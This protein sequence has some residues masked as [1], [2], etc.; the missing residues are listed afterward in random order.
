M[1]DPGRFD[2]EEEALRSVSPIEGALGRNASDYNNM[3]SLFCQIVERASAMNADPDA[4]LTPTGRYDDKSLNAWTKMIA[5]A[6]SILEGLNKMRNSDRLTAHIL[7]KH[8]QDLSQAV[9]V[10]LGRSLREIAT[11]V[12]TSDKQELR[13][14]LLKF[15]NRGVPEIFAKSVKSTLG[16]A[17][18]EFGLLN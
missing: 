10:E 18:E 5:T 9:A 4:F 16:S 11:M 17:K 14:A 2:E 15:M 1:H 3:W 6:R 7:E 8:A 13:N 12:D